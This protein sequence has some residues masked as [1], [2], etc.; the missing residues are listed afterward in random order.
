MIG[1]YSK[2]WQNNAELHFYIL[3]NNGTTATI[4]KSTKKIAQARGMTEKK[5]RQEEVKKKKNQEK[6][7]LLISKQ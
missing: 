1:I 4:K 7:A 5:T 3:S 6:I 2:D